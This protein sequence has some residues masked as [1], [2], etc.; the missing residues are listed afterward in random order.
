MHG[1]IKIL[2]ILTLFLIVK[3]SIFAQ[4]GPPMITDDPVTVD[5]GHWEINNA[6]ILEHTSSSDAFQLPLEDFNYGLTDN[7]HIKYEVPFMLIH[8]TGSPV[9]GGFGKSSIGAKIRFYNNEKSKI[10]LSVFPAFSFN[11][12]SSSSERGITDAGIEFVLP[13]SFLIERNNSAIVLEA[14]REFTS[15]DHGGW[16]F[17]S[18]YNIKISNRAELSAEL[19]GNS[20]YKFIS[21]EILFNIGTRINLSKHFNLLFSVGSNFILH[22][23]PEDKFIGYLGLQLDL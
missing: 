2:F 13:V 9:I 11:T 20:D 12:I 3:H 8:N 19:F 17:G 15:R 10:S 18:L 7:I 1:L 14:G 5:K 22:T 4:G 16:L 23:G 6:F 21:N